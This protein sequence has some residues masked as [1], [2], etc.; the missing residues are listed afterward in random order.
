MSK[1]SANNKTL[2]TGYYEDPDV[3]VN[4]VKNM[5]A[6]DIKIMDILTPFPIHGLDEL[7]RLK[8]SRL[9]TIGFIFGLIGAAVAFGFQTWVFTVDY[10]LVIGGKPYFSVPSF[11][12]VTFEMTILFAAF[13]MVFA[14]LIRSKLGFGSKNRIYDKKITD[15]HFVILTETGSEGTMEDIEKARKIFIDTGALDIKTIDG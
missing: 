11:I 1:K 9:P 8:K 10:P 15:D 5:M 7:I 4:A 6:S 13:A 12:P 3:M 2:V 14:F